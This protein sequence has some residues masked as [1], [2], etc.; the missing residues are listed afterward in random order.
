MGVI[1]SSSPVVAPRGVTVTTNISWEVGTDIEFLLDFG[2]GT[3]AYT[4]HWQVLAISS[5]CLSE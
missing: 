1:R 4:W 3:D 5:C 2:D